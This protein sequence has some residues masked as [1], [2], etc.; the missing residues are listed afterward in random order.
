ML[1]VQRSSSAGTLERKFWYKCAFD[2]S[3]WKR[4][5]LFNFQ[6]DVQPE[7]VEKIAQRCQGFLRELILRGCRNI[8]DDAIRR[9][10]SLC[11]LIKILDLSECQHLTDE[12]C[13]YLGQNCPELQQLSLASC[14]HI[15]DDGLK[16][17]SACDRLTHLDVSWCA[18]GDEG[19]AAIAQGCPGLKEL[20]IMG[21]H[22]VTSRGVGHIASRSC[23]LLLLS[24]SHCGQNI[25]DEA[26]VNL[27]MGCHFLRALSISLCQ[28]TD[29]GLRA[30]AGTLPPSTAAEMLGINLSALPA[31]L[32]TSTHAGNGRVTR[33]PRHRFFANGGAAH[34]HSSVSTSP[35]T[36]PNSPA[37]WDA[38]VPQPKPLVI[39]GCKELRVLEASQCIQ[40][41]DA[42]L[43]ALARNCVNLEKLDLEYCS[44][45]TDAT[46]VQLATYCPRINT[47]VLSH[48]DQ[49]TDEGI[50]R[51]VGGLCGPQQL[52]RLA[53]DN[54]PLLT[55]SSLEMLGSVCQ[56]LCQVDLYDC[57][58]ITRQGIENLKQQ[59]PRLKIQ[60]FFAPGTPPES[61]LGHRRRY[62]RC[63]AIL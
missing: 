11:R 43:A 49:I 41:T 18:V 40:I 63:C 56:N 25:T 57:Q 48:C 10:T 24:L 60:A 9:F 54:C 3:N 19:L 31:P 35:L 33:F 2:G 28:I 59:N 42:G 17:L 53:M 26:M 58:L 15:G 62:C 32:S 37:G 44:Q 36:A 6:R 30:L 51:L 61:A 34:R 21:C 16:K 12:T 1:A 45:V 50:T 8:N 38:P 29:A 13:K 22:D 14:P 27:A 5:N 55:D 39:A 20:K 23:G 47:L 4:T 46:L 7:V 52:Q